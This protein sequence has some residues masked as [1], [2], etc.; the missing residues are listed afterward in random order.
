MKIKNWKLYLPDGEFVMNLK[1]FF[2]TVVIF[3]GISMSL[4]TI[5]SLITIYFSNVVNFLNKVL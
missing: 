4:F 5:I 2:R 1:V 3:A